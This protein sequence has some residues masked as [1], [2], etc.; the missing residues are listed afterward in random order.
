MVVLRKVGAALGCRDYGVR[1]LRNKVRVFKRDL[2]MKNHDRY[3]SLWRGLGWG[4]GDRPFRGLV[5]WL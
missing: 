4:R 5:T 2:N 1:Q 3:C